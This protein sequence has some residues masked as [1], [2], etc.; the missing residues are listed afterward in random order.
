M[1]EDNLAIRLMPGLA[2]ALVSDTKKKRE[3]V[4]TRGFVIYNCLSKII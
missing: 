4:D 1:R 2:L 3:F